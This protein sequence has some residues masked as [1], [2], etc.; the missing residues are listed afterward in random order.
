[1]PYNGFCFLLWS[2]RRPLDLTRS[3]TANTVTE[4]TPISPPSSSLPT[5]FS[6]DL[7]G[8][9][10]FAST[11]MR[12]A[13]FPSARRFMDIDYVIESTSLCSP[14]ACNFRLK[15]AEHIHFLVQAKVTV[16]FH[17]YTTHQLDLR[18]YGTLNHLRFA[19]IKFR[20]T[21]SLHALS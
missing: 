8:L 16:Y 17:V 20:R 1:M 11:L 14:P 10:S 6:S 2:R 18:G 19:H 12:P 21:S 9:P 3:L 13:C 7:A 5:Y 15:I 4:K